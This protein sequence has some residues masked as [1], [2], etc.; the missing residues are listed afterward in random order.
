MS[1][2]FFFVIECQVLSGPSG[3]GLK[4]FELDPVGVNTVI[5]NSRDHLQA[6]YNLDSE[7]KF[8]YAGRN[9]SDLK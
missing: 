1:L 8:E 9:H 4:K 6:S 5:I 2:I 7:L 3:S